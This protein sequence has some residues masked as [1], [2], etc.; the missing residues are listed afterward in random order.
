MD[1]LKKKCVIVDVVKFSP[2]VEMLI[3]HIWKCQ[4]GNAVT[5]SFKQIAV[6]YKGIKH[7]ME[8]NRL[9]GG[10]RSSHS[11][12][13]PIAGYL[14]S[15]SNLPHTSRSEDGFALLTSLTDRFSDS[16]PRYW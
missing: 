16:C 11:S 12:P 9:Q 10:N 7:F 6:V 3:L 14:P 1:R 2:S 4:R 15:V 5:L 8:N 13:H